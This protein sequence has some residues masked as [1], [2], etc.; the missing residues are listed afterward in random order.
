MVLALK[1][2]CPG[3]SFVPKTAPTYIESYT[4]AAGPLVLTTLESPCELEQTHHL[5]HWIVIQCPGVHLMRI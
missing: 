5:E 1:V 4:E 3:K 2:P